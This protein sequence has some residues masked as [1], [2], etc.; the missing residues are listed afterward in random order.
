MSTM[1]SDSTV[2]NLIKLGQE[3]DGFVTF[4]QVND[5]VPNDPSSILNIESVHQMLT[6]VNVQIVEQLPSQQEKEML[7]QNSSVN[8]ISTDVSDLGYTGYSTHVH[9]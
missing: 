3:Q 1:K 8:E 7:L 2:K 5:E 6:A 4:T 9:T